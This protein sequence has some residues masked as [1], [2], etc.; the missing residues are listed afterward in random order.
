[1]EMAIANLVW[2]GTRV[3]SICNV[4]FSGR[5]TEM[6]H[7]ARANEKRLMAPEGQG[8]TPVSDLL[9]LHEA[10]RLVCEET[11]EKR[12]HRHQT[13]SSALQATLEVLGLELYAKPGSTFKDLGVKVD[14]AAGMAE[15][16]NH[17]Q[18]TQTDGNRI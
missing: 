9:A 17:L 3:L 13:R 1:M 16:E 7:R 11:I 12:F 6:A 10:M 2:T 18:S 4:F 15:L 14:V 8:V 5:L